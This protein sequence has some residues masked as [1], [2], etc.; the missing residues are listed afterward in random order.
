MAAIL[1]DLLCPLRTPRRSPVLPAVAV[2]SLA[3]GIASAVFG[4]S[5][6]AFEVA[7]VKPNRT[8]GDANLDS[9]GG[10]LT[11]TNITVRELIRVAFLVK[12]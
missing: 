4:Q 7:S 6:L 2:L 12:D 10:R 5:S 11:A 8:G 1:Q 9:R 3:M